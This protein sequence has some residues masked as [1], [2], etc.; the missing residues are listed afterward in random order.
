VAYE[1]PF[2]SHA[3]MDTDL[4]M[5][6]VLY[7]LRVLCD[8]YSSCNTESRSGSSILNGSE[9]CRLLMKHYSRYRFPGHD[10]WFAG[11]FSSSIEMQQ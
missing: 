3:G 5:W 8:L 7:A 1:R 2:G 4:A 6:N 9:H 11:L 10:D